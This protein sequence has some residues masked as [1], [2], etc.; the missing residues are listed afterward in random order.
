MSTVKITYQGK[1]RTSCIH[2]KSQAEIFTDAPVD[3]HG[4]GEAFSPTDLMATSLASCILTTMAI[5]AEK[6]NIPF[7]EAQAE[8]QKI[9]AENPRRVAEIIVKIKMP[10]ISYTADQ[11]DFLEQ[12]ALNCPVAKSLSPEIKQ[13]ITFEY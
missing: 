11:K 7:R 4:K 8:M 13:N 10:K 2:T 12:T 1:L 3:N 5:K 6:Q 9:M